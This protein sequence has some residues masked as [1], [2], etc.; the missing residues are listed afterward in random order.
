MF[1]F[2]RPRCP[3]KGDHDEIEEKPGLQVVSEATV[4]VEGSLYYQPKQ[5]T[6][7]RETPQKYHTVALF[8]PQ[9]L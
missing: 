2:H 8:D 7:V 9:K 5:C 4:V 1:L 6:I 3:I